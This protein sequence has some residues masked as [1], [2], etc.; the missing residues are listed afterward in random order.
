MTTGNDPLAPLR[1]FVQATTRLLDRTDDEA[2]LLAG[3][4]PLLAELIAD[5]DRKS[6]V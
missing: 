5:G 3:V 1:K 6:V 2:A 4:R